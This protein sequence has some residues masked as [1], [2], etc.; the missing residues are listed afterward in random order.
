MTAS[1]R[2]CLVGSDPGL[3]QLLTDRLEDS[4][5]LRARCAPAHKMGAGSPFRPQLSLFYS[6]Q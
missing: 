6:P 4:D 2:P 3:R 5:D 1:S